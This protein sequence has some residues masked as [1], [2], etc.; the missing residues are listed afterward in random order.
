MSHLPA[1]ILSFDQV[2]A[3]RDQLGTIV[4]TSG[5]FDP[6]HPGHLSCI[7]ASK[8]FGDTV[9]VI[10]NGDQFL[11]TK[12][13]KPFQNLETRCQIISYMRGVDI[14]IPF[15]IAG[16]QTVREALKRLRP[17]VFAKGGDRCSPETIPEW[18]IC[19][20]LGIRVETGV[21]EPKR[22][23]SSDF[24]KNWSENTAEKTP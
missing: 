6:V 14:V 4:C 15:E 10:V 18:D 16:D 19:Q 24:L 12:K 13:G 21:G 9:I 1:P 22:W 5:G 20:E 3:K 8:E 17:Q 7:T 23:S 2:E 11:T